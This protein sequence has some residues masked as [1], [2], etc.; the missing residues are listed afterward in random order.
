MLMIQ[1]GN[2][3]GMLFALPTPETKAQRAAIVGSR[4]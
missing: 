4:I 3:F 2:D 1:T